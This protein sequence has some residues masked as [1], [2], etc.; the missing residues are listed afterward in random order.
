MFNRL[1]TLVIF[2]SLGTRSVG[3]DWPQFRGP[4]GDGISAATKV[5]LAWSTTDHVVWKQP[6]PGRGW[7]SP[8]LS[9]GRIYLTTATEVDADTVSLRV[10]CL[11]AADGHTVWDV[12]LFKPEPSAVKEH[13]TKNGVAS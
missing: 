1:L 8:V 11:D 9:H 4:T 10:L 7:S 13:H 5:P 6:I 3:E 12:E 2:L